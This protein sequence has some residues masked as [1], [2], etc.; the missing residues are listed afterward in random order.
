MADSRTTATEVVDD[1]KIHHRSSFTPPQEQSSP[2][3]LTTSAEDEDIKKPW[4]KR[5]MEPGHVSQIIVAA[6]IALGI[7]LGVSAGVGSDN[8]PEAAIVVLEIPGRLWLRA[9]QAAVIPMIVCAM[10]LAI[11]SLR[12][13][14]SGGKLL[15]RWTVGYYVLTT[16]FAIA[17]SI[18][19]TSQ[20]WAPLMQVSDI[21]DPDKPN[22]AWT[23]GSD[24]KPHDIVQTL[25][26]TL[27]PS[28][29]FGAFANN[30]LLSVL[31]IAIVVGYLI[32]P[33]NSSI[34]HAVNEVNDMIARVIA[35][36]IKIAPIGVFHLILP[37]MFKLDIE[38]VGTNLGILIGGSISSMLIHLWI[39]L[40]II[41]FAFVRKNP[42]PVWLKSSKAWVTAW[43]TASSAGTMPL[44]LRVC[45]E[46][47]NPDV[48]VDFAV[49]LGTLINMDGTSIYFPMVVV[50]LA[51]TSGKS[52]NPG[53]YILLVLLSTLCAIGTTPIPSSSLVLT[54]MIATSLGIDNQGMFGVVVAIDWFIDRFR[55]MVN[56][57]GDIFACGILTKVTGLRDP[58]PVTHDEIVQVESNNIR[59]NDD[60]V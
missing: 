54:V 17:F 53:E 26:D 48:V 15:G 23:D 51:E 30:E 24:R 2:L 42:Y 25:F 52:L 20:V 41:Y 34:L 38:E 49:P 5:W 14:T 57:S 16:V 55:T 18:V 59:S 3:D 58:E 32:K 28:N 27:V 7:G 43:G 47:G 6:V 31:V 45:R 39:L 21:E 13:I 12:E 33:G 22:K 36:L 4:H 44:T 40:P 11:Q 10:I 29:V 46:R 60:R 19:M 8:I 35:F 50:F 9:L 37:N 1:K 56:V